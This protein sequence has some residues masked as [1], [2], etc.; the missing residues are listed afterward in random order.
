MRLKMKEETK[1]SA[2]EQLVDEVTKILMRDHSFTPE[3]AEE[4]I[5]NAYDDDPEMWNDNANPED[6]AKYVA[7]DGDTD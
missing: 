7:S 5:S 2:P 3:D 6:L 4:A 1:M